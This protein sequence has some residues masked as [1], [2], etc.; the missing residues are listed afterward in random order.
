MEANNPKVDKPAEQPPGCGWMLLVFCCSSIL[1]I[2]SFCLNYAF[3]QKTREWRRLWQS[4]F[5]TW[6][7]WHDASEPVRLAGWQLG[8]VM[9]LLDALAGLLVFGGILLI[10][11][12]KL[13]PTCRPKARRIGTW[14]LATLPALMMVVGSV[15]GAVDH[16]SRIGETSDGTNPETALYRDLGM[17]AVV[18]STALFLVAPFAWV[19]W[20]WKRALVVFA[21]CLTMAVVLGMWGVET[22]LH[23][24]F[25]IL[26]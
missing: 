12:W 18:W 24:L 8:S 5:P 20:E 16:W 10:V 1:F 3:V 25:L 13:T 17:H 9:S 26:S 19:R 21:F 22:L 11:C 6:Q 4:K 2:T 15:W 7:D 23:V 14:V